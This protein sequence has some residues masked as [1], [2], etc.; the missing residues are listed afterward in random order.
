MTELKR[1]SH[2]FKECFKGQ[3]AWHGSSVLELLKDVT[4]ENALRRPIPDVHTIWEIVLHLIVW[5]DETRKC[6]EGE[7][8]PLLPLD[9]DWPSI[10]DTCEE[11]W[12]E[13][14]EKQ[15]KG[16][17]CLLDSIAKFDPEKLDYQINIDESW[18]DPWS[19]TSYYELLHGILHHDVYHA[20]QMVI[21]KKNE[22]IRK[23]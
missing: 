19:T 7:T 3:P 21:L 6:L 4:S 15:K 1:I 22:L 10:N 18:P 2:L 17:Q 16:H 14:V 5:D 20:G 8:L 12:K 13:T 9:E 23:T 11:A